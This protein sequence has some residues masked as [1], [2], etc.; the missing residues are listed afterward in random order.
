MSMSINFDIFTPAF[1]IAM[2]TYRVESETVRYSDRTAPSISA[3]ALSIPWINRGSEI[4]KLFL[5][6]VV[7]NIREI[8]NFY[9][10][11][12]YCTGNNTRKT[13]FNLAHQ[14]FFKLI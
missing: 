6:C 11:N 10:I 7:P 3:P 2:I 1:Y 12:F 13:S 9:T 5:R 14:N 8:Y 4:I